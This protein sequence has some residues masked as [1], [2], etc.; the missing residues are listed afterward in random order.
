M[1]TG[2]AGFIGQHLVSDLFYLGY[3]VV[4]VDRV[5]SNLFQQMPSVK[6]YNR[7][8]T[9][10]DDLDDIMHNVDLVYH[11]ASNSDVRNKEADEKDTF[12]TTHAVLT[13][14]N[15]NHVKKILFTSSS[16]VY[17]VGPNPWS[18]NHSLNPIS[19]YGKAK[20]MSEILI[21]NECMKKK[22]NAVILRLANVVGKDQTHG[23]LVDF[24]QKLQQNPH[25]LEIKGNG[26]QTKE[27]IHISD[28]LNAMHCTMKINRQFEIYN[29]SNGTPLSVLEI[30]DLVC[31]TMRLNNVEYIPEKNEGGWDGDVPSYS[32]DISKLK[33][34]GW[35]CQFDSISAVEKA[36]SDLIF[37]NQ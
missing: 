1:I 3:E 35:G 31:H 32:L 17:G 19:E 25:T 14:M 15:K 18:E 6:F 2:G 24:I 23:V 37:S 16:A 12:G 29:V 5:S 7:D 26:Q 8:I 27:Y 20:E 22:L 28:V 34:I 10:S 33:S 21:K 4:A 11:L 30:A 36:A 13:S 9:C